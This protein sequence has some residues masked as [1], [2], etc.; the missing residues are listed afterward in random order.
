MEVA[1]KIHE[2]VVEKY[3]WNKIYERIQK[4]ISE[5]DAAKECVDCNLEAVLKINV[6]MV[7]KYEWNKNIEGVQKMIAV[8]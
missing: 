7:E 8:R 2:W 5:R 1:F 6:W 3:K 4:M